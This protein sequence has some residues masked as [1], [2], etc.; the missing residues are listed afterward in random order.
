MA[1][2]G[3][4]EGEPKKAETF[5]VSEVTV[6]LEKLY[7]GLQAADCQEI[8]RKAKSDLVDT[9]HTLTQSALVLHA[10]EDSLVQIQIKAWDIAWK[11]ANG[12]GSLGVKESKAF[13]DSTMFSPYN[14]F[15]ESAKEVHRLEKLISH[16]EQKKARAQRRSDPIGDLRNV[17]DRVN[18]IALSLREFGFSTPISVI[19]ARAP[20]QGPLTNFHCVLKAHRRSKA[21]YFGSN[22]DLR[23][24]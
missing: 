11:I 22:Q 15:L 17:V 4:G 18:R 24:T 23:T 19:P 21:L 3:R 5:K 7:A 14:S 8:A 13:A 6:P 1:N 9:E 16:T 12:G 10:R 20:P 2:D